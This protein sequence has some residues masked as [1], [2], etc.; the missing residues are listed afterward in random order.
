MLEYVRFQV[1][2]AVTMSVSVFLDVLQCKL[3]DRLLDMSH[4]IL[5]KGIDYFY[6]STHIRTTLEPTALFEIFFYIVKYM[7]KSFQIRFSYQL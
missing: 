1:I 3:L 6:N 5:L 2:A 4:N 7:G